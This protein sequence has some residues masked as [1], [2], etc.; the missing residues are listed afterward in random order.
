MGGRPGA[1]EA[2]LQADIGRDWRFV[3][4]F[5]TPFPTAAR[6]LPG[7]EI[8]IATIGLGATDVSDHGVL[9]NLLTEGAVHSGASVF[10]HLSVSLINLEGI[11]SEQQHGGSDC[12]KS[13]HR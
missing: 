4:P 13:D 3:I 8:D 9:M 11:W 12:S 2:G 6:A 10:F 7:G 5:A 1:D